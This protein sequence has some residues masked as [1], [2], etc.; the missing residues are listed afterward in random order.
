MLGPKERTEIVSVRMAESK[1]AALAA[2]AERNGRDVG[3]QLEFLVTEAVIAAGL[4]SAEQAE[5]HRLRESL[6]RRFLDAADL[7]VGTEGH[8]ADITAETGRRIM[9][10]P[11]WKA[12]YDVYLTARDKATINPT[13]GR[14]VKLRWK[15]VTGKASPVPKPS[16]F[17]SASELHLPSPPPRSDQAVVNV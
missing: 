7:I 13:L 8:R 2:L 3:E 5:L 1:V 12:D 6:I 17:S 16:I 15:L 10:D 14:R 11:G 4:I 9:Q